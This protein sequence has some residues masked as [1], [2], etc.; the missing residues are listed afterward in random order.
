MIGTY[1]FKGV[2]EL[3]QRFFSFAEAV[4]YTGVPEGTLR[5][6]VYVQG[7]IPRYVIGRSAVFSKEQ[8]D[9]YKANGRTTITI[10]PA[11]WMGSIDAA[12][13]LGISEG[14]LKQHVHTRKQIPAT[15]IANNL[16]FNR[17]ELDEFLRQ[18]G[19]EPEV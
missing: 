17:A 4:T 5:N 7:R 2:T 3:A 13:Y 11:V 14:A 10:N 8:L 16:L 18:R 12:A 6:H 15:K 19:R 9:D 1:E